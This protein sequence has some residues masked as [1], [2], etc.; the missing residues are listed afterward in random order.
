MSEVAYPKD[1]II[2]TVLKRIA[3]RSD[4]GIA[5]FGVTMADADHPPTY[6]IDQA[7]EEAMDFAVYL[8]KLKCLLEGQGHVATPTALDIAVAEQSRRWG[9]TK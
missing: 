1:P 5:K 4:D 2:D 3:K 6:W 7:I 9:I 8:T